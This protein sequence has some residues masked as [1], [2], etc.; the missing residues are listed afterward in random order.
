MFAEPIVINE[1]IFHDIDGTNGL[2]Y[3]QRVENF[4]EAFRNGNDKIVVLLGSKWTYKAWQ[5]W[6]S[7]DVRVQILSKLLYLGIL[8]DPLKRIYLNAEDVQPLPAPL[9]QQVPDDDVY[10]FQS[11]IAGGARIIVTTDGRLIAIVTEASNFEI[12]LRLREDFYL[13]YLGY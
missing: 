10:L 8:I 12:E 13:E 6:K 11:A 1:W 4:L 7:N 3:Q 5:L 2:A 9:A